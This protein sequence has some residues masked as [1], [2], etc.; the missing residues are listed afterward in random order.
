MKKFIITSFV[1]LSSLFL[2]SC[3]DQID[4]A[5]AE[6][7]T[8]SSKHEL[9]ESSK[10]WKKVSMI[11][12]RKSK[13]TKV[14]NVTGDNWKITWNTKPVD[15]DG[16]FIIILKN[17]KD[18]KDSDMIVNVTGEDKDEANMTGS[19]SYSLLIKTNQEYKVTVETEVQS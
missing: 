14:F 11:E 4:K 16:E 3:I 19:G 1:L 5:M 15:K 13:K 12:G 2:S 6:G 18:K 10:K 9:K 7:E 17:Q 8:N